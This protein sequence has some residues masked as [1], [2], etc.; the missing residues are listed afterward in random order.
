MSYI[1][2]G[3]FTHR[4]LKCV[5]VMRGSAERC[6]YVGIPKGHCLYG[7]S[8][9]DHL[10]IKKD[11]I[12]EREISGVIPLFLAI[13]DADERIKIE[14]YFQCHGGITYSDGGENSDYP[15][16]SDL[17]WFGFDCGHAGDA[18]DFDE[19]K[20]LFSGDLETLRHIEQI[21]KVDKKYPLPGEV[22]RS[23]GYVKA[24]CKRLAEQLAD[25]REVPE[26]A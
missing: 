21:E 5:V 20:K 15:I 16:L 25:F 12:G 1:V 19:A 14:A 13:L 9:N 6:G 24:E 2:E 11:D 23:Y 22:V 17:W 18:K 4:G 10:N 26:N 3:E 8:Y 7:K